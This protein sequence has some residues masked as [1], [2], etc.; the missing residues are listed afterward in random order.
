M[1]QVI[2]GGLRS[3]R[4]FLKP[5]ATIVAVA[6]LSLSLQPLGFAADPQPAAPSTQSPGP[7]A[8]LAYALDTLE[9]KLT[10]LDQKLTRG[11]DTISEL[12]DIARLRSEIDPL[13]AAIAQD[14]ERI[15][16]HLK[17]KSLPG[18]ILDRHTQALASYKQEMATLKA[19][20][21]A[22]SQAPSAS[23][24]A[25]KAKKAKEHLT[26]KQAR[27]KRPP[28]DPNNLP[29]RALAP[30]ENNKPKLR[31]EQFHA[32]GLYDHPTV[33][34]AALGDFTFDK[35]PGANDPAYLAATPE[36]AL[37]EAIKAKAAEL[38]YNPV[39][40]FNWVH[41]RTEW[42]PTWGAIQSSDTA[43]L[44]QKGNAFDLSSLLIALLRASGIPAR[45]VHGTI[46]IPAVRF[47]NWVGGFT[48]PNGAWD[49]ASAAGIPITAVTSGGK[50]V[51]FRMEHVWVEA[52]L[53]YYPSG[54]AI[55]KS[56]DSWV[57][58]DPSFKQYG[59][60]PAYDMHTRLGFNGEQFLMDY[61]LNGA[62]KTPYQHYSKKV[63]DYLKANQPDWT[64]EGLYGHERVSPLK[65]TTG[66][67]L[68]ELA[69]SLPYK[70]LARGYAAG[71][72]PDALR[73]KVTVE[74][75]NNPVY[76]SDASYTVA[77]SDLGTQRLTLSYIPE[78]AA[79]D[80]VVDDYGSLFASPAYLVRVKPVLRKAGATV[81][82]GAG[83]TLG[84]KQTLLLSFQG[85]TLNIAPV[86]N[87]LTAGSYSAIV[88]HG[89]ES[90]RAVPSAVMQQLTKNAELNE[91]GQAQF[92]DLLG[93]LLHAIGVQWFFNLVYERA[94][95]AT[96]A[97]VAY[98]RLPSEAIATADL[99]V[100]YWFGIPRTASP[101]PFTV[102]ADA[103]VLALAAIGNNTKRTKDFMLVAGMTG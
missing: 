4:L 17:A 97:Q 24:R 19:N 2:T 35:L 71:T 11:E 100:S 26:A 13:D 84:E 37:S 76:G 8:Q 57:Q 46:E 41:D 89:A 38:E 14:F 47:M 66:G 16:Q 30:N 32:A 61:L 1:A 9:A 53:D 31:K 88:F 7:A 58:L 6:F 25:L 90:T 83:A 81:A 42:L 94:F 59:A 91:S 36:V 43:L 5:T 49:L 64:L 69:A 28:L 12:A 65:P 95:Y 29:T 33:K 67:D 74:I 55:N 86:A 40:I 51:A 18:I 54:G 87:Q 77:L 39:K 52:A 63:L 21:D 3:R 70:T 50:V 44:T 99:S 80:A 82:V 92:D 78:S 68:R 34:L 102:D 75:A 15:G 48:D 45:Y 62:D 22:I 79:D 60:E 56:A 96:T 103:D 101:G 98:T 73:H 27:P 23:D 72:I 10:R 93:Q 20:L 85:P